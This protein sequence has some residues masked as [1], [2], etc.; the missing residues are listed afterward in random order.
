MLGRHDGSVSPDSYARV[1]SLGRVLSTVRA[2]FFAALALVHCD[3]SHATLA[4]V[5]APPA[6]PSSST[7]RA[8]S[9]STALTRGRSFR[10]R[11]GRSCSFWCAT[12]RI[13]L[14]RRRR[15]KS[16]RSA[17]SSASR[18]PGTRPARR[19]RTGV[20]TRRTPPKPKPKPKPKPPPLRLRAVVRFPQCS[21]CAEARWG[22]GG[23][24]TRAA[25]Y[26]P[27][28]EYRP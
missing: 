5:P 10:T 7:Q 22:S 16:S 1:A 28:V 11:S 13:S 12:P 14:A 24:S 23:R 3:H 20:R 21:S 19:F 17:K 4:I 18:R 27:I 9:R 25:R 26:N 8:V 6:R 15:R 2:T